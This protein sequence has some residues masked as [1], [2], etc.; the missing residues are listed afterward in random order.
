MEVNTLVLGIEPSNLE[1]PTKLLKPIATS[2]PNLVLLSIYHLNLFWD[3]SIRKWLLLSL[4]HS[5]FK[6]LMVCV[7]GIPCGKIS[8]KNGY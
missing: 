3:H 2:Y 4:S 8:L 5:L 6:R 1:C 7:F